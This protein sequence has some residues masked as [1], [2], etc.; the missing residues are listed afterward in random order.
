MEWLGPCSLCL[1]EIDRVASGAL[2]V[3]ALQVF[4][5]GAGSYPVLYVGQT[6]DLPRRLREHCDGARIVRVVGVARRF[7]PIYF[8]ILLLDGA[9]MLAPAESTLVRLLQ[10]PGNKQVP[11]AR[12][13][14]VPVP[15]IITPFSRLRITQPIRITQPKWSA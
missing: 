3:Y 10:P 8:S 11:T 13:M 15:P 14:L 4:D 5:P 7:Q 2:G 6:T 12:P 9:D 1:G